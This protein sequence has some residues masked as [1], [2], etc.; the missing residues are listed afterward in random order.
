MTFVIGC[1][2]L[3]PTQSNKSGSSLMAARLSHPRVHREIDAAREC[4]FVLRAHY[5]GFPPFSG[6]NTNYPMVRRRIAG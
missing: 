2:A 4:H 1:A 5:R 6:A 3:R